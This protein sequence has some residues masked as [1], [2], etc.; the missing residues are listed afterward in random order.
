MS[1]Q[2][3]SAEQFAELFHHYH[4]ALAS[5][6][7]CG[8]EARDESWEEIPDNERR[9]IVAAVRLT[10]LDVGSAGRGVTTENRNAHYF[11]KPGEAE[12]GC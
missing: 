6:F 9:R 7:D 10:L 8:R 12:W 5:D 4:E 3:V 1:I 11:P 2:D